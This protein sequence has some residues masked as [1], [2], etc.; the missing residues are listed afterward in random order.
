MVTAYELAWVLVSAMLLWSVLLL[1]VLQMHQV[2]VDTG[3]LKQLTAIYHVVNLLNL[4]HR[5][6]WLKSDRK[7][8]V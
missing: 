2:R 7:S 3:D 5:G 8:V 6:L 4:V 1:L